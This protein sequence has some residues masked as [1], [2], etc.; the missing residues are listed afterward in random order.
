MGDEIK[1][2]EVVKMIHDEI[3]VENSE[4]TM[5]NTVQDKHPNAPPPD[6]ISDEPNVNNT[7]NNNQN[8]HPNSPPEIIDCGSY[9]H[10]HFGFDDHGSELR[11]YK[12]KLCPRINFNKRI[13]MKHNEIVHPATTPTPEPPDPSHFT[14]PKCDLMCK[15]WGQLNH[16]IQF[17]HDPNQPSCELCDFKCNRESRLRFHM[18]TYHPK[19]SQENPDPDTD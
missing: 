7:A 12:C 17:K 5:A 1:I 3:R 15:N 18:E 13:F 8:N 4:S 6:P 2:E 16:H 11:I 14:C 19:D 9:T 10:S